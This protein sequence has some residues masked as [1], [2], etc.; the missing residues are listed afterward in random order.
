MTNDYIFDDTKPGYININGHLLASQ[1]LKYTLHSLETMDTSLK[2]VLFVIVI[3]NFY[4][5]DG[6]RLN[7]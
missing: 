3:Q 2:K 4:R 5:Y 6:F 1:N 7:E